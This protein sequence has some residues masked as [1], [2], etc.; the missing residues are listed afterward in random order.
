VSNYLNILKTMAI[1]K[2]QNMLGLSDSELSAYL[3]LFKTNPI[4]GSQLSKICGIPRTRIYDVLR[5]IKQK[6]MVMEPTNGQFVPLPPR[7]FIKRLRT[8]YEADLEW[9]EEMVQ[10]SM[11]E[12]EV[13]YFW[14]IYGYMEVM[15]KAKEIITMA[16]KNLSVLLFPEEARELDS[17]LKIAEK[18]GVQVKYVSIGAPQTE[19]KLQVV[20]PYSSEIEARHKGRVFD[21]AKDKDEV[22]VGQF[23]KGQEDK[24]PINWVRN[25]WYVTAI[26]E[27]VRHDFFHCFLE[28]IL[29]QGL[30]LSEREL[31]IYEIVKREPWY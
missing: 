31:E 2:K 1:K 14:T 16:K 12:E 10:D 17:Y 15:D 23:K 21:L 29:D 6:G 13:D 11:E 18:R 20:H 22:L 27:A 7:E 5:A 9:F 25:H 8:R 26:W 24:S 30:K 19:F 4:N 3:A 28:K